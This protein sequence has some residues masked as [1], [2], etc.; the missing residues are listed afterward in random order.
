MVRARHDGLEMR[1]LGT[2]ILALCA[3]SQQGGPSPDLGR[4]RAEVARIVQQEGEESRG[5]GAALEHLAE[6]CLDAGLVDEAIEALTRSVGI[7]SVQSQESDAALRDLQG[8][9][10]GLLER[11]GRF[12][13]ALPHREAI[14][15]ACESG[16]GVLHADTAEALNGLGADQYYVGRFDAAILSWERAAAVFEELEGPD[17]TRLATVLVNLSAAHM[18]LGRFERS[19]AAAEQALAIRE[20]VLG[21]DHP[22]CADACLKLAQPLFATGD[23]EGARAAAERGFDILRAAHGVDHLAT[24]EAAE[25][26]AYI[27]A[28]T[29]SVE[30]AFQLNALCLRVREARLGPGHPLTVRARNNHGARLVDAGRFEEALPLF[31]RVLAEQLRA[32]GPDHPDTIT[33]QENVGFLLERVGRAQEAVPLLERALRAHVA[34]RGPLHPQSISCRKNLATAL[35]EAGQHERALER[36]QE[37]Y[38]LALEALGASHPT[39]IL[40]ALDG[41]ATLHEMGRLEEAWDRLGIA[42]RGQEAGWRRLRATASSWELLSSAG[43]TYLRITRELALARRM[44]SEEVERAAYASVL[45]WKS[46]ASRALGAVRGQGLSERAAELADKL[47]SVRSRLAE[48]VLSGGADEGELSRL[49]EERGRLER[50][51]RAAAGAREVPLAAAPSELALAL[52]D[53]VA[54]VDLLVNKDYLTDAEGGSRAGRWS[55]E[56]LTAWVTRPGAAPRRIE[57]GPTAPM[58]AAASAFV[59]SVAAGSPGLRGVG[60]PS[61]AATPVGGTVGRELYEQVWAPLAEAL[62]DATTIVL[63]PDDFLAA[64]PFHALPGGDGRRLIEDCVLV[65]LHDLGSLPDMLSRSTARGE[66]TA[67]LVGAVDYDRRVEGDVPTAPGRWRAL[68]ATGTELEA[69]GTLASRTGTRV[70]LLRATQATEERLVAALPGRRF[71]HL[72]THGFYLADESGDRLDLHRLRTSGELVLEASEAERARALLPGLTTGLVCAGAN[73]G[74]APGRADGMLTA[75]EVAGLDLWGCDLVVL[76][77]CETALGTAR[78]GEAMASLQ[79]AFRLA[80]ARAVVASLWAV[81]DLA[82]AELMRAFYTALW[83]QGLSR[84]EALRQAQLERLRRNREQHGA[85]LPWT[86]AAFTLSGDWR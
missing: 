45:A 51:L 7:R 28:R 37:A 60:V 15:L 65:M 83:E 75:E 81:D 8:R 18:S 41:S 56:W 5:H 84:A 50:E 39:T 71:V 64:V 46:A 44:E 47:R 25:I 69:L 38:E 6:A 55:D 48:A 73:L 10:A 86:W 11:Q 59:A 80:G 33:A 32:S 70:E 30:D 52:P 35:S 68:A 4:A 26:L 67:V 72:A 49:R 76:S 43:Q 63:S 34:A 36:Y 78:G 58:R 27:L 9:L 31:E 20:Q 22:E 13:E 21:P 53:G 66:R 23:L 74:P 24:A 77:A 2:W 16:L 29:G 57:V 17:S 1:T 42:A 82:T 61:G 85:D 62:G 12:T 79:R 54:A 19:L 40:A 3:L 14:A